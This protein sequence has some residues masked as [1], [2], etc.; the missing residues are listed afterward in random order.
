MVVVIGLT[1]GSGAA[2][3]GADYSD[4]KDVK[5]DDKKEKKE[6]KKGKKGKEKVTIC[7]RPPGN[8]SNAQTLTLGAPGA[9]AH[10]DNHPKDT[11]GPCPKKY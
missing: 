9:Q 4:K 7:H 10:L 2:F 5:K 8:P 1:F 11:K 3:A 6:K